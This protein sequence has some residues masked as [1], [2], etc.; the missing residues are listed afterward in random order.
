[1]YRLLLLTSLFACFSAYSQAP[2]NVVP[3]DDAIRHALK[4]SSLTVDGTPFHA[5]LVIS[6]PSDKA[7]P[8]KGTVEVFWKNGSTYRTVI[9]SPAF[10]Q[11][12]IVNGDQ[13]EEHNTGDFYPNWLREYLTALLN[14]LPRPELFLPRPGNVVLGEH[15]NTCMTHDDRPGGITNQLTWAILCI[16]GSEPSIASYMDFTSSV[17]LKDFQHF[18]KNKLI[19]RTYQRY[20]EDNSPVV[21]KLVVVEPL[22]DQDAASLAIAKP[23]PIAERIATTFVSTLKEESLIDVADTSPWPPIRDGRTEG[24]MIVYPITDRSG[25]VREAHKHNSDNAELED[26]GVA[27]ALHYKFKPLLVDGIPQQM[28]MPLVLHFSSHIEDP[29][30]VVTGTEISKYATGCSK[31]NLPGDLAPTGTVFHIRYLIGEEGKVYEENF[32]ETNNK[33][34]IPNDLVNP[35]WGSLASCKFKPYIRDGKPTEYFVLFTFTAP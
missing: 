9:D 18:G 27:R 32:P 10:Q 6:K 19:A 22:R 17:E 4:T 1:M 11:L 29:R 20:F 28:E 21:G 33:P 16:Q 31:P 23:T 13:V 5:E 14:P 12:R 15:M 2:S 3:A 7:S 8:Y 34:G 24:Y 30:P 35:A 25:Q 26:A